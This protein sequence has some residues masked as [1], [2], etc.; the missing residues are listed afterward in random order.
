[1]D[2]IKGLLLLFAILPST[3]C[4]AQRRLD[5]PPIDYRE[6]VADNPIAELANR[7]AAGEASLQY[8][9]GFG[10]LRSILDELEI[11]VSSQSLV[12]S[13]TSLQ[14]SRISPSNPRAFYFNDDVYIGWIRGSSLMEV[15][16]AD[17]VLGAVF[18]SIQMNPR[19]ASIRREHHRCLVCHEKDGREWQSSDAHDY[20]CDG[21]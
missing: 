3:P 16:T 13:K 2:A 19:Q 17:P 18:Y 1:M 21:S 12:F 20:Q 10:Y 9:P 15:A 6:T 11:P 14:T 7:L 8:E 5:E 4:F